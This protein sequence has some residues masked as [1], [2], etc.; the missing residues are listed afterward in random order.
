[1][2]PQHEAHE[3]GHAHQHGPE[4]HTHGHEGG[5]AHAHHDWHSAAYV[6][7]WISGDHTRDSERLPLLRRV[8]NFIPFSHDAQIRV[9]DIGAGYGALSQQVL[10]LFPNAAVICQ[11]YSDPMI[12]H[13]RERLAWAGSR[14]SF[15]K[16]DLYDP[17]WTAELQRPFDA[18]VSSIC[19]HNLRDPQRIHAVYDEV[20]PLVWTKGAFLNCDLVR[21]PG[22]LIA[23][24]FRRDR[25]LGEN[26][27]AIGGGQGM[28]GP[29]EDEPATLENQLRWLRGS[30]FTEVDCLWKE[31]QNVVLGAFRG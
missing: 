15:V 28:G 27:P 6:D 9:L 14:V 12:G 8:A 11:D 24:A 1:V 31:R 26:G 30:G 4:G 16:A 21:V 23:D 20:F 19:I 18:V 13:A 7:D 17:E 5:R 2:E 10:E 25:A 29:A 22:P 3:N